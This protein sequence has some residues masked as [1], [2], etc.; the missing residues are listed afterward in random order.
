[1]LSYYVRNL[2]GK[3]NSSHKEQSRKRDHLSQKQGLSGTPTEET[4]LTCGTDNC[5]KN[6]FRTY[7]DKGMDRHIQWEGSTNKPTFRGLER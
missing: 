4:G 2:A 5:P 1:M 7:R 3:A 6:E